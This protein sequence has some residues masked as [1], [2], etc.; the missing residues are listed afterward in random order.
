[1]RGGLAYNKPTPP[2]AIYSLS[3]FFW[4]WG[5]LGRSGQM[6]NFRKPDKNIYLLFFVTLFKYKAMETLQIQIINP[7]AKKLLNG[8]E[9]LNLISISKADKLFPLS[10]WQ[11]KSIAVSRNQIKKGQFKKHDKVMTDLSQW[12]N[13]K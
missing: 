10:V 11:K 5:K 4:Q 7:K 1:M 9:D 8:L 3:F 13:E 2:C 6:E 12:L